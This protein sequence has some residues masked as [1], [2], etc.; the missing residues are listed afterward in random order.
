MATLHTVNFYRLF[1]AILIV[2]LIFVIIFLFFN[3]KNK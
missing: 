1:V 2:L 3:K